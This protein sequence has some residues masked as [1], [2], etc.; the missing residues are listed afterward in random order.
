MPIA[1]SYEYD[2]S[3]G[4]NSQETEGKREKERETG[5]GEERLLFRYRGEPRG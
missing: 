2:L 1:S 5:K 3:A 4:R